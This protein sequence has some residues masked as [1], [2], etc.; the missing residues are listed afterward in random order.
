MDV[1]SRRVQAIAVH[2]ASG[3]GALTHTDALRAKYVQDATLQGVVD[4]PI[5]HKDLYYKFLSS[6]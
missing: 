6:V 2:L 4:V 1:A 3:G 5:A